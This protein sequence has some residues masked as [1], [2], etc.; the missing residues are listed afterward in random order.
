MTVMRL[1]LSGPRERDRQG[2][3]RDC[4]HTFWLP[5]KG[6]GSTGPIFQHSPL[7]RGLGDLRGWCVRSRVQTSPGVVGRG[8]VR[9]VGSH[10]ECWPCEKTS[11]REQHTPKLVWTGSFVLASP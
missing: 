6:W 11:G 8:P 5:R 4:L 7:R 9:S 2:S 3:P 10:Q 1:W